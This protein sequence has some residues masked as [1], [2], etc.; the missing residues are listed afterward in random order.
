MTVTVH[1]MRRRLAHVSAPARLTELGRNAFE[2]YASLF[3]VP[4]GAGDVVAPGAFAQSLR[5][6]GRARVRML[7]QHFAHEPI[8]VWDEI[9][10]DARGLYVRGHLLTDLERGRDVIAL[11]RDGALNGLSI[12]FRTLRARRDPVSGYRHL[13][14]VEL[15]EV[16]VVT[17]PLLN[18]SEVTAIGTKG[19]ELV[20]DLRRASARLRA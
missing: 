1:H 18:G 17:F 10:E 7:Y 4:D 3:G 8:G 6:R 19:N 20:R 14:E 9:R 5:K 12:G 15:W 13:L 16:S 11:L 2:G